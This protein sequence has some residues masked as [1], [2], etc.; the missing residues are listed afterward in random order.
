MCDLESVYSL[1]S[2]DLL[3]QRYKIG[4]TEV[5]CSLSR[6]T[7]ISPMQECSICLEPIQ[8][9][10]HAYLTSCGHGFHKRCIYAMSVYRFCCPI[11]RSRCGVPQ[12]YSTQYNG[13][14]FDTYNGDCNDDSN[15]DCDYDSKS[16]ISS[17]METEVGTTPK[18]NCHH[19][20][21]NGDHYWLH[22]V[23]QFWNNIDIL[24]PAEC[25][26]CRKYLGCNKKCTACI[27]YRET[28]MQ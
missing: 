14:D 3:D 25:M 15:S 2:N 13:G 8:G 17:D 21:H 18:Q 12:Y 10:R 22:F 27:R 16:N 24:Y 19:N 6:R 20:G 26:V 23:D 1:Y 4:D 11:C 28:G 7:Y 9:R 5:P